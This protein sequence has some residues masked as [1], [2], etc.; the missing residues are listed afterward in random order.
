[1]KKLWLLNLSQLPIY[2]LR[3]REEQLYSSWEVPGKRNRQYY[4]LKGTLQLSPNS[5][6]W[7]F[8]II[9]PR[10]IN[11]PYPIPFISLLSG[12]LPSQPHPAPLF[13]FPKCLPKRTSSPPALLSE[14]PRRI[15]WSSLCVSLFTRPGREA[16]ILNW[17]TPS[18]P[19][20]VSCDASFQQISHDFPAVKWSLLRKGNSTN[21]ERRTWG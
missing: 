10:K 18:R 13:V 2:L 14:S 4:V 15:E 7:T 17:A 20:W 6:L 3:V 1:M 19:S 11:S 8:T 9:S 16:F 12:K 21:F 5:S